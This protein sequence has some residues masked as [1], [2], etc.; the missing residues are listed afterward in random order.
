MAVIVSIRGLTPCVH[1]TAW[2]APNATLV[3]DVRIG[4]HASV[5]YG[6]VLRGDLAPI[7][8]GER[9]NIQDNS[10]LHVEGDTPCILG[11]DVTVGHMSVIHGA[12]VEEACLI[13]M[14]ATVLSHSTIGAGSIVAA[15][16]VILEHT[17][18]PPDSLY[19]GVPA[20]RK[21]SLSPEQRRDRIA[22]A[23]RYIDIAR[24]QQC[25]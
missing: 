1:P 24:L 11:D 15:G 20:V 12:R 16:T 10:V 17:E 18:C 14:H 2:V 25:T 19:A 8:I 9:S 21:K 5:F 22:H 3:G 13:G 6:C 7:I 4:A 23:A